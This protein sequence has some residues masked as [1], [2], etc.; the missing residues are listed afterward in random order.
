M[1]AVGRRRHRRGAP[2][3]A[4]LPAGRGGGALP[5]SA[6]WRHGLRRGTGQLQRQGGQGLALANRPSS[7]AGRPSSG[8]KAGR[9]GRGRSGGAGADG[10]DAGARWRPGPDAG[11]G[12]RGWKTANP[13]RAASTAP[14]DRLIG[15]L[16]LGSMPPPPPLP[17]ACP[18]HPWR[19]RPERP[20]PTSC[21]QA[22][23][24]TSS[25]SGSAACSCPDRYLVPRRP[26]R[27]VCRLGTSPPRAM[28]QAFRPSV[29]H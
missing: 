8:G 24:Q 18:N 22:G 21:H 12:W 4:D 6:A 27:S 3:F 28:P 14:P 11:E 9:G 2:G 7:P 23:T 25:G 1:P 17:R 10:R 13:R 19:R 5:A 26:L 15:R 20:R 29:L 16:W